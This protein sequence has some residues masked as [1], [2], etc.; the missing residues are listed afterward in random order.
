VT[1]AEKNLNAA[2]DQLSDIHRAQLAVPVAL[3]KALG[4]GYRIALPW[5][6][7]RWLVLPGAGQRS[8]L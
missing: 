5:A 1:D 4:G 6:G 8:R 3:F 7:R 2:R